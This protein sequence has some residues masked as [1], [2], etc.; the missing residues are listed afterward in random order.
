MANR[1]LAAEFAIQVF[2]D[3][4]IDWDLFDRYLWRRIQ[5]GPK[6]ALAVKRRRVRRDPGRRFRRR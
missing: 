6:S 2:S 5:A 3:G 1:R 4:K